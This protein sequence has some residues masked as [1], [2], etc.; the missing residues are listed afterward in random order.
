MRRTPFGW[1]RIVPV[2]L[3]VAASLIALTGPAF[4]RSSPRTERTASSTATAASCGVTFEGPVPRP[5]SIL[6]DVSASNPNS[7]WAVGNT[8]T[9][10]LIDRWNGSVWDRRSSPSPSGATLSGVVSISPRD[11]WAVGGRGAHSLIEHVDG[12][13]WAIVAA[14]DIGPLIGVDG[15]SSD[16]VWAVGNGGILHWNGVAW[17]VSPAPAVTL[18]GV[19]AI[20]PDDAWAVGDATLH[21][22]GTS[23]SQVASPAVGQLQSVDASAGDDVWALGQ[24]RVIHWNG[25]AWIEVPAHFRSTPRSIAVVAPTDVW[26]FGL[27]QSFRRRMFANHWNGQRWARRGNGARGTLNGSDALPGGA[28]FA[29][30]TSGH[31][32]AE[33]SA[34]ALLGSCPPQAELS[35]TATATPNPVAV[36]GR[37]VFRLSVANAGPSDATHVQVSAPVPPSTRLLKVSSR[38]TCSTSA[39]VDCFFAVVRPGH[40]AKVAI[41]LR[42]RQVGPV[43]F[44]ATVTGDEP[45]ANDATTA[46]AKVITGADIS[47][48]IRAP[49]RIAIGEPFTYV[50]TVVNRGPEAAD[51]VLFWEQIPDGVTPQSLDVSQGNCDVA[52]TVIACDAGTLGPHGSVRLT[53]GVVPDVPGTIKDKAHAM[54]AA[55]DPDR[56]NNGAR[57]V[58]RVVPAT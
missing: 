6:A 13:P 39:V 27:S 29:V 26:V 45:K 23:W 53:V 57:M 49:E 5:Q 3:T 22:D 19:V 14:P 40:P 33:R 17:Q 2:L 25:T 11:A 46:R 1:T 36:G 21:W 44:K 28:L 55:A 20:A 41:A 48:R 43:Q 8:R 42:P 24:G 12:G 9:H 16:D 56:S 18:T 7:A 31:R 54:S 32:V 37:L 58:T 15:T 30:G 51:S 10:T 4:G 52:L 38:G 34:G 35:I 50:V 47:T